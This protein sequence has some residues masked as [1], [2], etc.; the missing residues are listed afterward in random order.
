[1]R[2]SRPWVCSRRAVISFMVSVPVLSVA[3]W[4]TLPRVSTAESCLMMA[5][6]AA[7][8]EA[9]I[10]RVNATTAVRP[11]GMVAT[12]SETAVIS[13]SVQE[14]PRRRPSTKTI[15]TTTSA[16]TVSSWASW[17]ILRCNGVWSFFTS[18]NST[19]MPPTAVPMPVSVTTMV[20]RPRVTRVFM[21]SMLVRS[22]SGSSASSRAGIVFPTGSDSPVRVA[23][24]TC[25]P[26]FSM[27]RPSAGTESPASRSTMSP[28]TRSENCTSSSVPSRRATALPSD[29][30]CSAWRLLSALRSCT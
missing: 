20:A 27:M 28:G 23:S 26:A 22:V 7:S 6:R 14:S 19:A 9:P 4:L 5:P 24:A 17:S 16:A 21:K 10:A 30:C 18:F 3:I 1:M 12:A 25:K 15:A 8:R 2:K 11:S 29:S 13:S